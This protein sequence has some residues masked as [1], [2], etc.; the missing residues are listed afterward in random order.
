MLNALFGKTMSRE[1]VERDVTDT[2]ESLARSSDR[3]PPPGWTLANG[4]PDDRATAPAPRPGTVP[5]DDEGD[6]VGG[7]AAAAAAARPA[8]SPPS[9]PAAEPAARPRRTPSISRKKKTKKVAAGT[10]G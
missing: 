5:D 8:P 1:E 10:G 4:L 6:P 7:P 9:P 3:P 2:I